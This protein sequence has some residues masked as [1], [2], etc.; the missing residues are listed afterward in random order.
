MSVTLRYNEYYD[1]QDTFDLL[2]ERSKINATTVNLYDIITSRENIKL[3]YRTI[4][5]NTGSKTMGTDG[6]T[7]SDYRIIDEDA[8]ING[9][10]ECLNNYHPK[11]VR[12]VFIPKDNGTQRP[13]GIPTMR[14]RLIQ[15]MFK[16][17]LEPIVEAKFHKHNYG[18]RPNRS[19]HHAIARS[20]HL[21]NHSHLHYVVDIDLKGFFD[22]VNHRKLIEQL[23]H[24]GIKDKRVLTII[25]R[26][27]K[28]EIEN[29]GV[30]TRGTPQGGLCVA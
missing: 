10:Q 8:F 24:I 6:L 3:A 27:L 25:N 19:T 14:D 30:P 4:K 23:H 2:Y 11:M 22:N 9:I 1:M 28:A 20:A 13:L 26:M 15:Q 7:I 29:E 16:Q 21:I 18:F 17:V 12:R 5:S